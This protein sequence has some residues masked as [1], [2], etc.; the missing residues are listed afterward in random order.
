MTEQRLQQWANHF[1]YRLGGI[2]QSSGI[3][4]PSSSAV[5]ITVKLLLPLC[6]FFSQKQRLGQHALY[7]ATGNVP[8]A[9]WLLIAVNQS[10]SYCLSV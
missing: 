6:F 4:G 3:S 7:L 1:M 2:K 5:E 8:G 9:L 10:M